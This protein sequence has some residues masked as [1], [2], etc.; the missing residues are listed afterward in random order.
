VFT[1]THCHLDFASFDE[2]RIL[3]LERSRQAGI[4]RILVPGINLKSSHKTIELTD[5]NDMVY[6]AV[7]FHPNEVTE[8]DHDSL[9]EIRKLSKHSKVVAIGEIGLD[10]FRERTSPDLQRKVFQEQLNLAQEVEL[11]VVIHNR[12]ASGDLLAILRDWQV[13]LQKSGSP[14]AE[15]PGVLHSFSEEIDFAYKAIEIKF[16]IGITGP[17]TFRNAQTLR[18]V[19]ATLPI[20]KILIETDAPFL[21]PHPFRGKRNEPSYVK[22]VAQE[23]AKLH[24]VELAMVAQATANNAQ[25]LFKW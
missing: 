25:M 16:F 5:Y 14:L 3:V 10:Y 18:S 15:R 17:V 12:Q 23:I 21:T 1:D 4:M 9:N 20:E 2:D 24:N 6:A 11:P 13:G 22:L 8:W 7:G 19:V